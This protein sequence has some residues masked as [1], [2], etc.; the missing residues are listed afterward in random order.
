MQQHNK[1]NAVVKMDTIFMNSENG[2]ASEPH[3]L[4]LKLTDELH[5]RRG[6]KKCFFIKPQYLLHME[7]HKN[8]I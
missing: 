8:I 7:K 3:V 5:L 1:I 4:M 2:K 6:E